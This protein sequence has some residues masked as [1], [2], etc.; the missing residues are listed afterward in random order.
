M[1]SSSIDLPAIL[2]AESAPPAPSSA[3]RL[4]R[5][6]PSLASLLAN[7]APAGVAAAAG[8][9]L[10]NAFGFFGSTPARAANAEALGSRGWI[11][12]DGDIGASAPNASGSSGAI[13]PRVVGGAKP[14]GE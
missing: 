3:S 10:P 13:S 14:G 1:P 4:S 12:G 11:G 9:K 6:A 8:D 7:S 2:A 5:E